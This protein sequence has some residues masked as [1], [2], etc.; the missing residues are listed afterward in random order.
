[1]TPAEHNRLRQLKPRLL[2]GL[3]PSF[4]TSRGNPWVVLHHAISG[5]HTRVSL[6]TWQLLQRFDGQVTLGEIAQSESVLLPEDPGAQL[7]LLIDLA[8]ARLIDTSSDALAEQLLV[9]AEK[10]PWYRRNPLA[11]RVPLHD[12]DVWLE[13]LATRLGL[14]S[15]R[16]VKW[17]FSIVFICAVFTV[18][19]QWQLI[20]KEFSGLANSPENWWMYGLIYPVLKACHELGHAL[21]IKRYG[22]HVHEV[23]ITFLVLMPIPYVDASDSWCIVDKQQRIEVSAAGI[24]IELLLASLGL[25]IW[26]VV[27]PLPCWGRSR[28]SFLMLIRYSV[29]MVT[30]YCKTGLKFQTSPGGHRNFVCI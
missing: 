19:L 21:M 26:L 8:Q 30:T 16:A 7:Q 5:E 23:G 6:K 20:S 4:H 22:G 27:E 18:V 9:S 17:C 1:M 14:V 28:Q 25:F 15:M 24:V 13:W 3:A 11:I 12:P 2:P 29:L 10:P